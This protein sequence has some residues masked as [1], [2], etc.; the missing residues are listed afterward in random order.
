MNMCVSNARVLTDPAGNRKF[1]KAKSTGRIDGLVAL[2]MAMGIAS[3]ENTD[4][5]SYDLHFI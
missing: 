5:P 3:R 1:E 4:P 2:A